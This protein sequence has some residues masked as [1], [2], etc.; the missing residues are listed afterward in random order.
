MRKLICRYHVQLNDKRTTVSL[1]SIV[2][3]LMAIKLGEIPGTKEAHRAIRQ[4]MEKFISSGCSKDDLSSY[5]LHNIRKQAIL[6]IADKILSEKILD[7]W[8]QK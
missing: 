8:S 6:F 7:Y 1:D 4:Q 2:S 5:V 3:E